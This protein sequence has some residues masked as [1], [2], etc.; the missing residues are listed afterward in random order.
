MAS[1]LDI[2]VLS[3]S[4][5]TAW[6][7]LRQDEPCK[8]SDGPLA[9]DLL[10]IPSTCLRARISAV[11]AHRKSHTLPFNSPTMIPLK[12]TRIRPDELRR[13]ATISAEALG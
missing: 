13:V 12:Q 5:D 9:V 4:D 11:S 7:C 6:E 1:P 3:A 8:T 2:S 10:S